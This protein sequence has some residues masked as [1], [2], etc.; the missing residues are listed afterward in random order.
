MNMAERVAIYIDGGN[1]YRFL[2]DPR[3]AVPPGRVFDYTKFVNLLVGNRELVFKGYY[4]GIIRNFDKSDKSAALVKG[5]QKFLSEIEK[6][7]FSVKRGKIIYDSTIREKGVDVKLA[8]DLIIGA[9]DDIYDTAIVVSSD[10]DLVPAVEHVRVK[11]KKVEY[12]GFSHRPSL[13]M[14]KCADIS[15][16]L[17]QKDIHEC[18]KTK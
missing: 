6:E 3:V 4:V 11:N 10:T 9:A 18:L 2:K 12:I 8:I 17:Q 13:G 5:Q 7:G 14:L 15:I 16:L 1:L